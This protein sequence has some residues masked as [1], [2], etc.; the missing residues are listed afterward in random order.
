M[1]VGGGDEAHI[2]RDTLVAAHALK[3]AFGAFFFFFFVKSV[4]ATQNLAGWLQIVLATQA[5]KTNQLD[6]MVALY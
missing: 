2:H 1:A 6:Q 5:T 3:A 4:W